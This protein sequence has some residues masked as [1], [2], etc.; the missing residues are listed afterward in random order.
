MDAT[1]TSVYIVSFLVCATAF[2]A[3][4]SKPEGVPESLYSSYEELAPPKILYSC[5]T[6]HTY[7]YEDEAATKIKWNECKTEA[8]KTIEKVR[9]VRKHCAGVKVYKTETQTETEVGYRASKSA[10]TNYNRLLLDARND[11]GDGFKLIESEQQ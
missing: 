4:C 9:E 2:L 7:K 6:T 11:C 8:F 5:T 1:F 10:L 3:G